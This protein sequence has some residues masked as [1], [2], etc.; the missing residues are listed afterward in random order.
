MIIIIL[1]FTLGNHYRHNY[2]YRPTEIEAFRNIDRE[3]RIYKEWG[4]NPHFTDFEKRVY[5]L[6]LEIRSNVIPRA[7]KHNKTAINHADE[8]RVPIAVYE[9]ANIT[10]HTPDFIQKVMETIDNKVWLRQ[11]LGYKQV[12]PV[13]KKV[14]V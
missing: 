7:V 6:D 9:I 14:T 1:G 3:N 13:V 5:F 11:R 10:N 2:I 12:L 4:Y 8:L